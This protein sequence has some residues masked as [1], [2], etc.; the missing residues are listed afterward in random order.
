[1]KYSNKNIEAFFLLVRA[2]LFGC[3]DSAE[4]LLQE[5]VDWNL[6]HQLAEEQCVVG[7]IADGIEKLRNEGAAENILRHVPQELT[8][9]LAAETLYLEQ[10]NLGMDKFIAMLIKRLRKRGIHAILLKGQGVAQY[11]EKP[12][13]R[14]CGDVDLLLGGDGYQQA[15]EYLQ[16]YASY[17]GARNEYK[18]HLAMVVNQWLVEL[19][20]RLR[21]GYSSRVDKKLDKI[22]SETLETGNVSSWMNQGVEVF[23]LGREN[24]VTYV[25]VHLLNHFYKGGV[26]I[27][28]ICDWCRLLW[29]F[30][31]SLDQAVLESQLKDMGLMKEWKAFGAYAVEYLGLPKESLPFYADDEKWKRKAR[32]IHRF[33]LKTGNM[34]YNREKTSEDLSLP[35]RKLKS[36]LQRISDLANHL[37]IFPLDTLRFMPS[38]FRTGLHQE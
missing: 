28:Q 14:T 30:R 19:H 33:I 38:I 26:G 15:I 24:N 3:T 9:Q 35:K 8:L 11:Y 32:R 17:V 31:A 20:G 36:A 25:F 18:K 1:M 27:R 7:L 22:Y 5:G 23:L 21:C 12:Q 4:C 10:C 2:G 34:G 16:P 37:M 13:R 29:T 6:V